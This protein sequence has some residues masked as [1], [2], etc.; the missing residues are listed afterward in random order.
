MSDHG[1]QERE[2]IMDCFVCNK[3]ITS[4]TAATCHPECWY[5]WREFIEDDYI[6]LIRETGKR[7]PLMTLYTVD[8]EF[9][10]DINRITIRG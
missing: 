1:T 5:V 4:L 7:E 10:A 8:R 9:R 3:P 6:P 2:R